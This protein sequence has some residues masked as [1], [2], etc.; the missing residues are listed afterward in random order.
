MSTRAGMGL[1]Q[2]RSCTMAI[3]HILAALSGQSIAAIGLPTSRIP[4]RPVPLGAM[5]KLEDR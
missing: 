5:A 1:C 4:I 3:Q 2:G